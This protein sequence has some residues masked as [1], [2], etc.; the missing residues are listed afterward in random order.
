MFVGGSSLE[1]S[2]LCGSVSAVRVRAPT[3]SS[4]RSDQSRFERT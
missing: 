3:N 4:I 2:V 1:A